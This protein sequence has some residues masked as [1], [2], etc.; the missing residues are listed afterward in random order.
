M[1]KDIFENK[2]C[3]KLVC[4]AGNED[5]KEVEK[6]VAIYSAAGANFFDVC[7]NI[8][9]VKS[10]KRGLDYAGIKKDR[11]LCISIGLEGDMHITKAK[12]DY[13]KCINC[14]KCKSVCQHEA[15][16][17]KDAVKI[18]TTRCLGC[19]K[20]KEICP[21]E[22]IEM[23]ANTQNYEEI[24]PEII[25]E[26][27]DCIEFHAICE[28]KDDVFEKWEMLNNIFDGF[29]CISID[30][31]GLGDK[32][33]TEQVRQMINKRKPYTTI[34]QADGVAMSGNDNEAST[35]LQALATAQMFKN[36][37]IP[38]YIMMSGGTN[39]KS[40]ELAKLFNIDIDAIAVGSYARKIVKDYLKIDNLLENKEQFNKAVAIAKNFIETCLKDMGND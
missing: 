6:L 21:N 40:C 14:H 33:L 8:N 24:L 15:I 20:C 16:D 36:A 25:K 19:S 39:S 38:A 12:I 32:I 10:A 27:I 28:N 26:N 7:A 4:G 1:L 29:L 3:F 17:I 37:K 34:I 9:V 35:T 11:Y 5:V 13:S 31:S 18:N 30:R 23:Y 2:K 22:A